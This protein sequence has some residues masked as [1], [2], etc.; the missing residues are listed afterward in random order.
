MEDFAVL[1]LAHCIST[2]KLSPSGVTNNDTLRSK[3][4]GCWNVDMYIVITKIVYRHPPTNALKITQTITPKMV[5]LPKTTR[6]ITENQQKHIFTNNKWQKST[7]IDA[8]KFAF[9]GGLSLS[10]LSNFGRVSNNDML[11]SKYF[12]DVETFVVEMQCART[13]HE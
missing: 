4:F 12:P 8:K 2:A 3:Y 5:L 7:I 10:T 9:L 6:R 11:R 1:V 13:A